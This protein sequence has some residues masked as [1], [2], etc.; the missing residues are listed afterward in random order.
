MATAGYKL[1]LK[2]R[3][4]VWEGGLREKVHPG[5]P[6]SPT[7]ELPQEIQSCAEGLSRTHNHTL[8]LQNIKSWSRRRWKVNSL[9]LCLKKTQTQQINL[10][11]MM[12]SED[13][14][15]DGSASRISRFLCWNP[16]SQHLR[17]QLSGERSFRKVTTVT[18]RHTR[19]LLQ[20]P[21][22][23]YKK[24]SGPRCTKREH[25]VE[26]TAT[27]RP[28]GETSEEIRPADNSVVNF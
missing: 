15:M 1:V 24:R 27:Y 2:E 17:T 18:A 13:G 3:G 10:T 5:C 19:A 21:W 4:A 7:S 20:Q 16:N 8:A 25:H 26:K 23:A 6:A 12:Q 22:Y 28:T 9:F 14:A 11:K